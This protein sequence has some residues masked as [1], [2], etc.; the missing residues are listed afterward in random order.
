MAAIAPMAYV[1]GLMG[2]YMRPMPVGASVAMLLSMVV[3][4]VIT[5]WTAKRFLKPAA[6]PHEPG[7]DRATRL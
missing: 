3:A 4:F 7:D 6:K 1:G 5:P 2:P